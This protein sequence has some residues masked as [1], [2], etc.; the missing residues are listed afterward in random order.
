[1]YLLLI[2]DWIFVSLLIAITFI[3]LEHRIIPD[4]LSLSGLLIGLAT[5][6]LTPGLGIFDSI[7]GAGFGF[8]AFYGLAWAYLRFTGRSGLG[9]GDIKLIAM[10][11]AFLGSGGVFATIFI[12]SIFGSLVGIAWAIARGRKEVM[13]L[14][15]PYGPFLVVGAL[16]Y[17]LLGD[18]LWFRF[19][20]PM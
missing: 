4:S 10:I 14:A 19:T 2:H 3:D 11:G 6:W 20:T 9:G 1:G 12:S 15:I 13:K 18:I 16:Y 17:Y 8:C 5:S 7:I